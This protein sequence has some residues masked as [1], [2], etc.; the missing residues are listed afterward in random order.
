MSGYRHYLCSWIFPI[1]REN[2]FWTW[3]QLTS[4]QFD[5][6]R[7]YWVFLTLFFIDNYE[8]PQ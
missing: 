3:N 2:G 6:I 7:S 1:K 8:T 5:Q 4:T